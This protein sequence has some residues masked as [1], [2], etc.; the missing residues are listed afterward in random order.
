[1]TYEERRRLL[2][3]VSCVMDEELARRGIRTPARILDLRQEY[4]DD[5]ETWNCDWLSYWIMNDL[6]TLRRERDRDDDDS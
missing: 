3:E 4:E 6:Q 1:M 5:P 2:I